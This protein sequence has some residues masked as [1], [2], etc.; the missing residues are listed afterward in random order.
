MLQRFC[1]VVGTISTVLSLYFN[2]ARYFKDSNVPVGLGKTWPIWALLIVGISLLVTAWAQRT[3]SAEDHAQLTLRIYG[4]S[5][6][7]ERIT[8]INIWRWYYLP[9]GQVVYID[10]VPRN[11]VNRV[12]FVT[13]QPEVKISTLTVNSPDMRLPAHEV[14]EFNQ[15]YAIIS[16]AADLPAGTLEIKVVP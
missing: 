15:R 14:K 11:S 9:T 10:G 3:P 1:M 4:D 7:P 5:R 8:M 6:A 12:L 13:F 2:A 16:F